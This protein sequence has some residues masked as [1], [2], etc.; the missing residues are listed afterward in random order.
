M[1]L[2]LN[3]NGNVVLDDGKPVYVKDDGTEQSYDASSLVAKIG[4]LNKESAKYRTRAKEANTKLEKFGEID[5]EAAAKAIK[6]VKDFDDKKLID[7]GEADR[8]KQEMSKG[9]KKQIDTLT[10]ERDTLSDKL[11]RQTVT[12]YFAKSEFIKDKTTLSADIAVAV[13]GDK[14]AVEGG[15]LKSKDNIMSK[16]NPGDPAGFEETLAIL[17]E[18]RADKSSILKTNGGGSGSQGNAGGVGGKNPFKDGTVTEQAA[19]IKSDP[20]LAKTLAAAAGKEI[21]GLTS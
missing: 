13:F 7:A 16:Q 3:E 18:S 10:G 19:V 15:V 21:P 4:E 11:N 5:P 1:K 17:I 20:A 12:S 9:Y 2:K 14:F 8:I 6:T